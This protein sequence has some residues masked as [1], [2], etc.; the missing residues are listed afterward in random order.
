MHEDIAL[1]PQII[2]QSKS[3]AFIK[4][5]LYCYRSSSL[6][7]MSTDFQ[8]NKEKKIESQENQFILIHFLEKQH[9]ISE[10]KCQYQK[11]ISRCA[12][13]AVFFNPSSIEK[14]YHF[15]SLWNIPLFPNF[16]V[17]IRKQIQSRI[18]ISIILL[19]KYF[20]KH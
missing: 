1:M 6:S 16:D 12:Y 10:F 14:Y 17:S 7:S 2:I 13:I 5:P 3:L 4:K 15:K 18:T 8:K 9:K 11:L 19:R 20:K